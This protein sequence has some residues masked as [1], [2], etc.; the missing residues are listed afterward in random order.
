M[1]QFEQRFEKA[2]E[3][4]EKVR[5]Y[6]CKIATVIGNEETRQDYGS[7]EAPECLGGITS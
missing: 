2:F 5:F 3:L 1:E 6:I 7:P 4:A